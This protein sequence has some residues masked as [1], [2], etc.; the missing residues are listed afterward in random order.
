MRLRPI[1]P[2]ATRLWTPEDAKAHVSLEVDDDEF[3]AQIDGFIL[4]AEGVVDGPAGDLN[5]ALIDQVWALDLHH[6]P[7]AIDCGAFPSGSLL[8][9]PSACSERLR[10]WPEAIPLPLGWVSAIGDV[11]YFD[12]TGVQQ[13]LDPATFFFAPGEEAMITPVPSSCWPLTQLGR[14][15]A[16]TV[17]LT[18]GYGADPEDVPAAILQAGRLLIGH[19]FRN[20]EAVVGVEN[21][22]SS[23]PLPLGVDLLL[24][25]FRTWSVHP[26]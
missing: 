20:R 11:T 12:E 4:A 7:R 16:V 5:R 25:R 3:D 19:W 21:R 18:A 22:D 8:S 6:F 26:G 17:N 9:W 23:T 13:T 2:P 24:S 1:T 15:Y 10:E 14:P